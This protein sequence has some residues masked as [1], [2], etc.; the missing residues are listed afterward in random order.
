MQQT[1]QEKKSI[2]F[3]TK[4][5]EG[6]S[7]QKT[8]EELNPKAEWVTGMDLFNMAAEKIPMLIGDIIP[9]SGLSA[10][11]GSSD[12]GKSMM[13]RQLAINVC[14]DEY[15]LNFKINARHRAAAIVS[16]EDDSKSLSFL[17]RRQ[18]EGRSEGLN[19]VHIFFESENVIDE[20]DEKLSTVPVDII[21]CDAWGDIYS[22]NQVDSG[23]IRQT[24]N[25]Y[26]AL[27]NKY[28]CSIVFLHHTGKRTQKL[29]PSKDN[30]LSGQGF[31]AK[32][33]VVLE[34][35]NDIEDPDFR[36]LC[37]VKGNYLGKE[38]KNAS[39]KVAMDEDTF[40][41][42]D[43]GDRVAFDE[44]A[45]VSDDGR[46]KA[47]KAKK[48][49][50]IEE[51]QHRRIVEKIFHSESDEKLHLSRT[52]LESRFCNKYGEALNTNFG[53]KRFASFLDYLINDLQIIKR[54]DHPP[55]SPSAFYYKY[56]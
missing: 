37:V 52:D 23:Q 34:L 10:L 32:M 35:R 6:F 9:Q 4:S 38:F 15:F 1:K 22:G 36:H 54:S 5:Q 56:F 51:D 13:L 39:F 21:I 31:E 16:T 25:R 55:R 11:V 12:T 7:E 18:S 24:L 19:N 49:I 20:L 41:F 3:L 43:T 40:L 46:P 26:K 45:T 48:P 53:G 50:E 8:E 17:I 47:E 28:D 44:L 14:R 30:I 29:S 33:R 27:A 2:D 42:H